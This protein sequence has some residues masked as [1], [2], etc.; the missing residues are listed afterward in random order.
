MVRDRTIPN[1]STMAPNSTSSDGGN[2]DA[3]KGKNADRRESMLHMADEDEYTNEEF[4]EAI[5]KQWDNKEGDALWGFVEHELLRR[6]NEVVRAT[7]RQTVL[8]FCIWLKHHGVWVPEEELHRKRGDPYTAIDKMLEGEGD[9][10]DAEFVKIFKDGTQTAAMG[11]R[12][13]ACLS[14]LTKKDIPQGSP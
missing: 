14:R 4:L 8:A 6:G 11:K 1:Q 3:N 9:W 13:D 5:M 2:T 12:Y 10:S 7:A